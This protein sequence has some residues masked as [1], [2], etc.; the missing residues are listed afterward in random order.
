MRRKVIPGRENSMCKGPMVHKAVCIWS[1]NDK[2][3]SYLDS[4][5]WEVR[6]ERE[7]E[8]QGPKLFDKEIAH[9]FRTSGK[10]AIESF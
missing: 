10:L 8:G 4:Q 1:Q 7:I 2:S 3:S 9:Y 6:P 5:K